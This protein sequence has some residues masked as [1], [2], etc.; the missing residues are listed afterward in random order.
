MKP[1]ELTAASRTLPL[2]TQAKVVNKDTGKAVVVTVNDRGPYAQNRVVDV[3]PKAAE[4]L[5]MVKQGV[6]NVEVQPL[7]E[8]PP[9]PK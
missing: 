1:D 7:R 9:P 5:G 3:T 6:A 2:G 8:P 4:A